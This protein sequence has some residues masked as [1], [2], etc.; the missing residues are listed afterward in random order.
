MYGATEASARL[1][2]LD[3]KRY[4]DKMES[5]GRPIEGVSLAILSETG[6]EVPRGEVGDLVAGGPNIMSG[7]WKDPETSGAV[8][9]NGYYHTGDQAFMDEEGFYYIVGRKDD[10][11]KVGGHRVNPLEIE[12]VLLESG[13]LLEVFVAGLPD[14]LLGHRLAALVV[15]QDRSFNEKNLE[16]YCLQ[17]LPKFKTPSQIT[18]VKT[19]P[20]KTSGK[21]DRDKCLELLK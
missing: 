4:A 14:P 17:H 12:D 21:I 19:L 5:I 11:L 1:T 7:Y 9:Q 20:K 16:S 6:R 10:Q 3:P 18:T 13:Q 15:P 2:C 8:L